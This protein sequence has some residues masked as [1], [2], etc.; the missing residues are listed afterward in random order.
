MKNIWVMSFYK[1]DGN[2]ESTDLRNLIIPKQHKHKENHRKELYNQI[3]ENQWWRED[4][5]SSQREKDILH[6]KGQ[7]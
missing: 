3:A 2:D 5:E 4:I 1:F 7:R 6:T